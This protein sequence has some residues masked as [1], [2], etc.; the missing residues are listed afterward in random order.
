[1]VS[2]EP[3]GTET[4]NAKDLHEVI[5]NGEVESP[6]SRGKANMAVGKDSSINNRTKPFAFEPRGQDSG[7][8]K[9]KLLHIFAG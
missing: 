2:A 4:S 6:Q 9:V 3:T 7:S 8:L 1:M 5:M